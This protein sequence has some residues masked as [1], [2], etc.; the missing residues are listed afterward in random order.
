MR[1]KKE[2]SRGEE[3]HRK[4]TL[5]L[6]A[7]GLRQCSKCKEIKSLSKFNSSKTVRLIIPYSSQCIKCRNTYHRERYKRKVIESWKK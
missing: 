1:K 4:N 7:K 5:T 6:Y 3:L 2:L